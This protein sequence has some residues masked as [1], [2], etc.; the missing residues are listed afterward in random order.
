MT[1]VCRVNVSFD[2]A[3]GKRA[4]LKSSDLKFENISN[5]RFSCIWQ[6]FKWMTNEPLD[7]LLPIIFIV[8]R[9]N[10]NRSCNGTHVQIKIDP[11]TES[12]FRRASAVRNEDSRYNIDTWWPE[13]NADQFLTRCTFTK[14]KRIKI[15]TTA[16]QGSGSGEAGCLRRWG[17][18]GGG[19]WRLGKGDL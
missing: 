14:I 12:T 15:I 6:A 19:R 10:Q 9:T 8:F 17:E 1:L 11:V 3:V 4:T 5:F 2:Q 7:I 18:G 16:D 13:K